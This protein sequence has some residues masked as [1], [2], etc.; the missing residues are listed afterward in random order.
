MPENGSPQIPRAVQTGLYSGECMDI[1]YAHCQPIVGQIHRIIV[2]GARHACLVDGFQ[3]F[4]FDLLT[5]FPGVDL[6][7][8][9]LSCLDDFE[10]D[11]LFGVLRQFSE[12]YP[13]R[14][15]L[16]DARDIQY[17][18]PEYI[19]CNFSAGEQP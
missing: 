16:L 4:L 18:D 9:E 5:N 15:V 1:L 13:E 2:I 19:I 11:M 8:V 14:E 12:A 17:V 3:E 6:L 7:S 10:G